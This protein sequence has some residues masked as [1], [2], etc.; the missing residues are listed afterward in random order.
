MFKVLTIDDDFLFL[1]V[2]R[3]VLE[4]YGFQPIGAHNG[5]LGLQLAQI[6]IPDLILC[7]LTMPGL[8]GYEV[9]MALRQNSVTKN[10]PVIFLTGEGTHSVCHRAR[11]LGANDCLAK[12]C[13]FD[14][15]IPAIEAQLKEQ[16]P[17]RS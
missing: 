5:C 6:Q 10:I 4:F 7:D 9:L 14:K 11:E 16:L 13:P 15:L 3:E 1:E 8:N 17:V 2:L 12:P